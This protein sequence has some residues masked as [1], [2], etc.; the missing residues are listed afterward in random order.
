MVATTRQLRLVQRS[1]FANRRHRP[2]VSLAL[3]IRPLPVLPWR[4]RCRS[5]HGPDLG[6]AAVRLNNVSPEMGIV[7]SS[8]RHHLPAVIRKAGTEWAARQRDSQ[9]AIHSPLEH[10][11][12]TADTS[13]APTSLVR[14]RS[15]FLGPRSVQPFSMGSW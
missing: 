14:A 6:G 13:P 9:G 3:L 2:K 7:G 10:H 1:T 15:D 12:A 8:Y 4:K 11:P 5:W